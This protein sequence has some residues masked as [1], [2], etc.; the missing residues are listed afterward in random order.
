MNM[1]EVI[2]FSMLSFI[3]IFL[4]VFYFMGFITFAPPGPVEE[5]IVAD[6]EV[7]KDELESIEAQ[8]AA[9]ERKRRA[10][11]IAENDLITQ[12]RVIE[13][14]KNKLNQMIKKIEK[15][16]DKL[17]E[18]EAKKV[19]KLA[20]LYES[21]KPQDA[22][23]IASSLDIDMLTNIVASMK[24]KQAAKMLSALPPKKA[25]EISRR[26]GRSRSK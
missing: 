6:P 14:E 18:E 4:G 1:R 10:I 22:A 7:I 9:L 24:E 2:L 11:Q 25:A 3:L 19:S 26:L 13:E 8:R 16:V 23:K 12:R 17:D 5:Q 21:M 15:L 20:K